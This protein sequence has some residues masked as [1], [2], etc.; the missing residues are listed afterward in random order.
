MD[1]ATSAQTITDT[2]RRQAATT[3]DRVALVRHGSHVTF[4][5]LERRVE[6]V[7]TQLQA[8]AVGVDD[9]VA[10][11]ADPSIEAFVAILAVWRAGAVCVPLDS[12]MPEW[13]RDRILQDS[14]ARVLV[15]SSQAS[16]SG[17]FTAQ[18]L[19]SGSEPDRRHASDSTPEGGARVCG[20]LY[21]SGITGIPK[22]VLVTG[23]ALV[24]HLRWMW[25]N[26][27]LTE[28][29]VALLY[30]P[31]TVIAAVWDYFGALLQGVPTVIEYRG[32][33]VDVGTLVSTAA[34]WRVTHLSGSPSLWRALVS[35]PA[36]RLRSWNTL[37]LAI[38]SGEQLDAGLVASW[39]E[40]F[41]GGR[42][43]NVYGTTEACRPAAYDTTGLDGHSGRAAHVPIGK[44]IGGATIHILD[45]E[46]VEVARG[47]VGEVCVAGKCL[48]DGYLNL[49]ELTASRFVTA[50]AAFDRETRVFRTGD[51]GRQQDDGTI[52]LVGRAD[53]QVQVRGHRVEIEEIEAVLR[54]HVAV[55]QAGV[56]ADA[57]SPFGTQL[58]AV[59]VPKIAGMPLTATVRKH[60]QAR[61]PEYMV[62]ASVIQAD[63][64]P[65]TPSGKLDRR[66][67][68]ERYGARAKVA[69][70]RT[71]ME[72]SLVRILEEVVSLPEKVLDETFMNVGGH[73][74]MAMQVIA[75]VF[76][77]CG[78]ELD[79]DILFDPEMTLR[80]VARHIESARQSASSV[81][82]RPG[83]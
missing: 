59:V 41:P 70:R 39:N 61:L 13:R 30:R 40:K 18:C 45:E 3:P 20:I 80:D 28:S 31:M 32:P 7:A 47:S 36:S 62:P 23:D 76:D 63:T 34:A 72:E 17:E 78:V 73:S 71:E 22:G 58:S 56:I 21:T 24:N 65:L 44:P 37:R 26:Y 55:A 81:D 6:A 48:A 10:V 14:K 57:G 9:R 15:V 69:E 11:H 66:T 2:F 16:D 27:A 53:W 75:R 25:D 12:S 54:E 5:E 29:D 49:P 51:L 42:L 83:S 68:L 1:T 79:F 35:L 46:L 60:L 19:E 8:E 33:R 52:V 4:A 77:K 64:I 50:P 67:L 82:S 43:L 38:S 74:L